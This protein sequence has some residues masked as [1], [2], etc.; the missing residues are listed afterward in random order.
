M[1]DLQRVTESFNLSGARLAFTIREETADPAFYALDV[2]VC[3]R[4]LH[5]L[6]N[7]T[8]RL[9]G[10]LHAPSPWY[11]SGVETFSSARVEGQPRRFV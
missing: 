2:A 11:R 5:R 10:R 4:L 6:N 3:E 7:T 9:V 8:Q 1:A